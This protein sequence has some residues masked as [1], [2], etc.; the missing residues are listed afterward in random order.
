MCHLKVLILLAVTVLVRPNEGYRILC[1]FPY[2][3]T[4]HFVMFGTLARELARRGHQVDVI[5]HFPTTK[6]ITNYTDIVSLRGTR[7]LM[8]SNLDVDSA[9]IMDEQRLDVLT[10]AFGSDICE[11]M[12]SYRLQKFIKNP[13]NDPPY[14]LVIVE[15]LASM[16]YLG[17]G[18]LLN[19]PVAIIATFHDWSTINDFI[20][21]S[22]NYAFFSG[23]HNDYAVVRTFFDRVWNFM[24]S[25]TVMHQFYY[26]TSVQTEIMRKYLGSSMPDI[27]Q[28]EKNVSLAL[29][30]AHFSLHGVR[31]ITP[32]FVEVGGLHIGNQESKLTPELKAWLDSADQGLVC[33]TLGSILNIETLP[34]KMLLDLY[35]SFAKISPIKVIMK[36][37]NATRL[38]R[39]LPS[40]VITSTWI[41]Q[42]AVL[43]H[44]NT[45]VFITHGGLMGTQ[46]ALYYGIPMIGIPVFVDQFKNVNVLVA[47][48]VAV[49]ININDVNESSMDA[50][51]TALLH[52]PKYR[53]SAKRLSK[54]FRDR[55]MR[56]LDTAVY[57]IEYVIRN[58]PDSLRSP[59]VDMPWWKLHLIDVFAFLTSCL[60]LAVYLLIALTKLLLKGLHK[61]VIER[62]K[63]HN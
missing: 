55:P 30:N 11:L 59:V 38:P 2:E 31:P 18:R 16:C 57:W 7:P 34:E 41:S 4:S 15:Y 43:K 39:G 12:G 9:T 8:H 61:G 22:M 50:A 27:R 32:A 52:N 28:L 19:A 1:V 51:L 3:G 21:N 33:F 25:T 35:A 54:V 56:P 42:A 5:S 44:R 53:E 46:E 20:G 40:N 37:L 36:C 49:R 23:I 10:S 17:F 6:P 63:K 47:K 45:R 58:G 62:E 48:N 13:P 14:D 24:I 60:A 29:V 26:K